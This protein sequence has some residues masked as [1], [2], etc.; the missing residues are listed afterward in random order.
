MRANSSSYSAP[1][2]RGGWSTHRRRQ[3]VHV[4]VNPCRSQS[5]PQPTRQRCQS[6]NC[7]CTA[8]DDSQPRLVMQTAV[9]V[10]WHPSNVHC[11][12]SLQNAHSSEACKVLSPLDS[13]SSSV[14]AVREITLFTNR[15]TNVSRISSIHHTTD[16]KMRWAKSPQLVC[17]P[18]GVV[19]GDC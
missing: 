13:L 19:L 7:I 3:L 8:I 4:H 6:V 12:F 1:S 10:T 14:M 17:S 5:Q 15:Y 18:Y 9:P 2:A 11:S 16:V